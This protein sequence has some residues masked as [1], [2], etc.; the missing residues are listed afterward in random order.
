MAIVAINHHLE[1]LLLGL[2]G[3]FVVPDHLAADLEPNRIVLQHVR[4]VDF[5]QHL[6]LPEDPLEVLLQVGAVL[7]WLNLDLFDSVEPTIEPVPGL[8]DSAEASLADL[9]ELLELA[10]VALRQNGGTFNSASPL[11]S[12]PSIPPIIDYISRRAMKM[13][14]HCYQLAFIRKLFFFDFVFESFSSEL[15]V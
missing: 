13:D 9:S 6:A 7:C 8:I 3:L 12:R 1:L 11:K 10:G 4:I 5:A 14:T 2:L 15:Y